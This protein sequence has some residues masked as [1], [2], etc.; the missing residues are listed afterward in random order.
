MRPATPPSQR[1]TGRGRTCHLKLLTP[2]YPYTDIP[3]T[4]DLP[5][6]PLS[7]GLDEGGDVQVTSGIVSELAIVRGATGV[8]F[9]SLGGGGGRREGGGGEGGGGGGGEVKVRY[10]CTEYTVDLAIINF[11]W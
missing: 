11:H 3:A 5:H 9:T 10:T 8:E 4:G 6:L 2:L 7:E 1:G